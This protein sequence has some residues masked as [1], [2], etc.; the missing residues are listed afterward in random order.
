[1]YDV[2]QLLH[3]WRCVHNVMT[4]LDTIAFLGISFS[5]SRP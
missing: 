5:A 2:A 1:M 3:G 4:Q